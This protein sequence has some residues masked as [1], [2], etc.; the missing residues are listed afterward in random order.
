MGFLP[1]RDANVF[2]AFQTQIEKLLAEIRG[3]ENSYVLRASSTELE[4]YYLGKAHIEPLRLR[5]D[6]CCIDDQRSIHVHARLDPNR[7]FLPGDD[8]NHIPGTQL[9]VAIPF[10]GD[11]ELWRISPSRCSTSRYPEID[12]RE[13][14]VL[15]T[16]QFADGAA[17][18]DKIKAEIDRSIGTLMKVAEDLRRDVAEHNASAP[19][20][21]TA[22]LE[23]KRKQAQAASGAVSSLGIPMRRR[24]EPPAYL[25]PI[26]RR[27][28]PARQPVPANGQFK[29]EAAI[30]EAEYQHILGVIRS[31]SLVVERNPD[32][33]KTLDEQSLR[34]SILFQLNGHYEG[35]ATGETF[36]GI[37]KTDILIRVEDRN[38]FI[39]ECK[40]WDGPKKFEEAIDQLF[41]RYLTWRDCKCALIIFNRQSNASA[42]A[43]KMHEAMAA[44]KCHR[45]S[46]SVDADKGSRY[47]FVKDSD[48]GRDIII[49]TLLFDVPS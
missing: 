29:P 43:Q 49:T 15:I 22:A 6:E 14:L 39:A 42:V 2:S 32:S 17:N 47:I 23:T 10:E 24:D 11:P 16:H 9:V 31:M 30:D 27:N 21:I 4:Q 38:I 5:T 3:L 35:A 8:P 25:A 20:R 18:S 34:D 40:F 45:K 26:T 13:N 36:N 1:F 44:H 46:V 48:P 37:G 7:V 41:G 28:L 33:F 12:L 19:A